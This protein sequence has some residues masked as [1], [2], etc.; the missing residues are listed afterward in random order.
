MNEPKSLCLTFGEGSREEGPVA[1]VSPG[2]YRLGWTP[3]VAGFEDIEVY[4]GDVIEAEPTTEGCHRFVRVVERGRFEHPGFVVGPAFLESG[5]F[6]A[7]AAAL[8]A[9]GGSWEVPINGWLL[10]HLPAG[11]SFDVAEQLFRERQRAYQAGVVDAPPSS[12]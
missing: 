9:A 3:L 5:Y 7:F 8:E 6:D 1:C 10:T 11:S 4:Q 12:D 2:C